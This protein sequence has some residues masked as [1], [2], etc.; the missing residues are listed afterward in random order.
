VGVAARVKRERVRE[1]R[2][3]RRVQAT[4]TTW[5]DARDVRK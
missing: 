1:K 3:K 5:R 2:G 4:D